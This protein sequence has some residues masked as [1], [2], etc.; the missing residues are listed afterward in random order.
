[1]AL[2]SRPGKPYST[3]W[4]ITQKTFTPTAILEQHV[5]TYKHTCTLT[6]LHTN[7]HSISNEHTYC[8]I[9]FHL[10]E[11]QT[12]L[13]PI[14]VSAHQVCIVTFPWGGE[15]RVEST[16]ILSLIGGPQG[17]MA[18]YLMV[19]SRARVGPIFSPGA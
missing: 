3:R 7:T 16:R 1:M 6:C 11:I 8:C 5:Y 18:G 19:S 12:T 9:L 13:Q 4:K 2:A 17:A 14:V 10:I 15:H